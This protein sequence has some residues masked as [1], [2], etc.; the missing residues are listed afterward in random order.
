MKK[1]KNIV[2]LKKLSSTIGF[3]L[4]II[5]AFAQLTIDPGGLIS[6]KQGSSMYIGTDFKINSVSGS[7]GYFSDQTT[8]GD[9]TITGNVSVERF[10][11]KDIWHNVASPVSSANSGVYTGTI[12]VFYYDE[13]MVY[14]DWNFGWVLMNTGTALTPFR[15]YDVLDSTEITVD[16]TGSG[17]AALNTGSY[18]IGVSLTN[19]TPTEIAS[20][21]GWNLVAN[22]YPSPVDW[23][24]SSGW[25]KTSINDAKYIWDGTNDLY[26][27][28]LGGGSP[29]GI[30]G[31][32]QYIPSNQ[33]FWVQATSNGNFG[34]AN[35]VRTGF[36]TGTPDF[37]KSEEVFDY[38]LVSLVAEGDGHSDETIVRFI[39]GTTNAFDRNW[40][41]TKLFSMNPDVPQL[42]F[43]NKGYEFALNTLPQIKDNLSV[44]LDFKCAKAGYYTINLSDRTNLEPQTGLYLKDM[45]EQKII[46]LKQEQSYGF[47]HDP[48]NDNAR[49]KLFFNPSQDVINNITP[50]DYFTVYSSGK[51][52]FIIKNTVIRLKG[53]VIVYNLQGQVVAT[54]PVPENKLIHLEINGPTG[55]Y[56]VRVQT[57][58]S[59]IN[60]KVLIFN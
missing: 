21:K 13:S 8:N 51:K 28:W 57:N 30:N 34:I 32:T 18:T 39:E 7:S 45:L 36:I 4:V 2:G 22:P 26:T 3:L 48:A 17:P 58:Q 35:A 37:Y 33:G 25:T 15:G 31:G 1:L 16:Y 54:Q 60:S 38:P 12:L 11:E 27:I 59:V 50:D 44:P 9:V 19:S 46:D 20:H 43:E 41:A 49:F 10:L 5:P 56:I 24:A 55:Y 42:Y 53:D 14:N 52:I 29:I 23:Q 47:Y 6:I 40:D